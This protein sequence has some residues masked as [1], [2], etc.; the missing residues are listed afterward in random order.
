MWHVPWEHLVGVALT[1]VPGRLMAV[2][3]KKIA[4]YLMF[5]KPVGDGVLCRLL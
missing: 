1:K 3:I 5:L 2:E 4:A